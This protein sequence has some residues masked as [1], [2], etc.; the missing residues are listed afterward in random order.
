M[1][2]RA[3]SHSG[4]AE[5]VSLAEELAADWVEVELGR[6]SLGHTYMLQAQMSCHP[7]LSHQ[8]VFYETL[9]QEEYTELLEA[10][11]KFE[12]IDRS[13]FRINP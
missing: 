5:K 13:T 12:A 6:K 1:D 11:R 10:R 9:A 3:I 2:R 4:K 8:V 7:M